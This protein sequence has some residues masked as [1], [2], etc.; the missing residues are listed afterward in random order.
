M[1]TGHTEA[2]GYGLVGSAKHGDRRVL[3]VLNGLPSEQSRGTEGEKLINWAFRQFS[4]KTVARKGQRLAEASVWMGASGKVG[5]VPAEDIQLLVPALSA[6][7]VT[8]QV[9]YDGPIEAPMA[10]GRKLADLVVSAPGLSGPR[11][12]RWSP[13]RRSPGAA[14]AS[15]WAPPPQ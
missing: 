10:A 15:G 1:K 3:V 12:S 11:P 14:S 9:V 4:M 2:S 5:L 7:Q 6:E 8:A 13:R